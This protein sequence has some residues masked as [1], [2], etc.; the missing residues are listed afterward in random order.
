MGGAGCLSFP[1][2]RVVLE[3]GGGFGPGLVLLRCDISLAF[4][5]TGCVR[6]SYWDH[7]RDVRFMYSVAFLVVLRV[8]F[9]R[10]L[11]S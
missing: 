4:R 9:S 8:P 3:V 6:G 7:V 5:R 2:D 10:C 11:T 1:L